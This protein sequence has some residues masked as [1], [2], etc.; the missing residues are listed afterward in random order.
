MM[1]IINLCVWCNIPIQG[2]S[3]RAIKC[4]RCSKE[5]NVNRAWKI[6]YLR[7]LGDKKIMEKIYGVD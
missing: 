5:K 3:E 2:R 6:G 1:K 4:G 7:G